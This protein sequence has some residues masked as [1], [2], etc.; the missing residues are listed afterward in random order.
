MARN[1]IFYP[2]NALFAGPT[3]C[4]GQHL[5]SGTSGTNL[6]KQ[7]HRIQSANFSFNISRTDINQLGAVAAVGREIIQQPTVNLDFS[8]YVNSVHNEDAIG[9]YVESDN[10]SCVKNLLD[11]SKDEKNYFLAIAPEGQDQIGWTGQSSVIGI[12]NGYISSYSTEA[13]VGG[14]PTASVSVEGLNIKFDTSSTGI[15]LPSINPQDGL[16]ATGFKAWIP[17]ATSGVAGTVSA[18]RPGDIE[19]SLDQPNFGPLITDAKIQSY[20][21]SFD[22]SRENLEKIGSR[23][24]FSKEIQFPVTV[25]FSVTANMGDL[26]TGSLNAI[27][28]TDNTYNAIIRLREANLTPGAGAVAVKYE[29]KSLKLDSQD[30]SNDIGSSSSVTMNFSTQIS[31]PQDTTVG[32]FITGKK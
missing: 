26:T 29:L 11:K 31:G 21:I 13:S 15:G 25:S 30:Y 18:L 14:I 10:L 9:M 5:S 20:N 6:V 3:P 12:G 22:L 23:F 8:Y 7:L 17:Q 1:R 32:L 16:S 27:L 2:V 28:G 19:F 24:A 4:T